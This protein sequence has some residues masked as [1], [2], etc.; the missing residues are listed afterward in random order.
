MT[1]EGFEM[2]RKESKWRGHTAKLVAGIAALLLLGVLA[3][4]AVADPS[5]PLGGVA[6]VFTGATGTDSTSDSTST[7]TGTGASST[8][9]DT[10][11]A[12]TTDPATT[13]T[14]TTSTDSTTT[15]AAPTGPPVSYIVTFND[16][17]PDAKQ[18]ADIA[19][20]NGT[21]GDAISV[22]SM[23]SATFPAG[24]DAADAAAL[25]AN[26]DVAAVEQDHSRDTAAIPNDT[27]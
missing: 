9:T 16:N 19:A 8:S 5:D 23:Y 12:T 18:R 2:G 13:S 22:L 20:A 7:S 10:T 21:P 25:V 4:G 11:D 6:S 27:G 15:D 24:E 3:S 14:D 1:R 26:A 17:V